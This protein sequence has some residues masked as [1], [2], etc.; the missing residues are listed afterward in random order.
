MNVWTGIFVACFV[1]FLGGIVV[2]D[3]WEVGR[4]AWREIKRERRKMTG[5]HAQDPLLEEDQPVEEHVVSVQQIPRWVAFS[6][7]VMGLFATASSAA[8]GIAYI[9]QQHA[10]DRFVEFQTCQ[11]KHDQQFEKIFLA[12]SKD[13]RAVQ[14][15]LHAWVDT[16]PAI[17]EANPPA[18]AIVNLRRTLDDYLQLYKTQQE[19]I[20]EHPYRSLPAE[21]GPVK[22]E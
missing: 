5:H 13:N 22:A 17:L 16:V 11:A 9:N 6:F 21:C 3:Q 4:R 10:D 18:N 19:F 14:D 1:S 7:V 15:A 12:R 8:A 2:E 20:R